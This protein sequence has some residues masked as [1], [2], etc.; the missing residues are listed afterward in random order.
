MISRPLTAFTQAAKA[1]RKQGKSKNKT[2]SQEELEG[3]MPM[4]HFL[5][6]A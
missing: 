4:R 3:P 6:H 5:N 1:P 2:I